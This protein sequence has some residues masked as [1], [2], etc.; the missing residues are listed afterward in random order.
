MTSFCSKTSLA[1][2]EHSKHCLCSRISCRS[3]S[4]HSK[5][6]SWDRKLALGHACSTSSQNNSTVLLHPSTR[7]RTNCTTNSHIIST[8]T[9]YKINKY[10]KLLFITDSLATIP[11]PS[12]A[13]LQD[14]P[15]WSASEARSSFSIQS[16][17]ILGTLPSYMP[18]ISAIEAKCQFILLLWTLFMWMLSW[19]AFIA[20]T[21]NLAKLWLIH[22]FFIHFFLFLYF[23]YYCRICTLP[24]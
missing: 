5:Y 14:M 19:S 10:S 23:L 15:Y 11:M 6:N 1:T 9:F 24:K 18:F 17:F 4:V 2:R 8:G 16:F 12:W 21:S 7:C 22:F 13:I 20:K 3:Q